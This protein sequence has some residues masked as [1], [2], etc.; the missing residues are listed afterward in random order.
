MEYIVSLLFTSSFLEYIASSLEYIVPFV[1]L[2][3]GIALLLSVLAIWFSLKTNKRSNQSQYYQQFKT[4]LHT[5]SAEIYSDSQTIEQKCFHY[6][7]LISQQENNHVCNKYKQ[8]AIKECCTEIRYLLATLS[9]KKINNK[10]TVL[11]NISKQISVI[12]A[13]IKDFCY[14]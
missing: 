12:D 4:I 6:L 11:D 10:D 7:R 1:L 3:S 5:L 8:N 2:L 13:D 14:K 9:N